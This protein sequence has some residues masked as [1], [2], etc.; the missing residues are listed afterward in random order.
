M[1][2]LV[3]VVTRETEDHGGEGDVL[4]YDN[5]LSYYKEGSAFTPKGMISSKD[6]ISKFN[7]SIDAPD[8]AGY[9]LSKFGDT[10]NSK[11]VVAKKKTLKAGWKYGKQ[12]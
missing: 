11:I 4:C 5:G 12:S 8:F 3:S 1:C 2:I 7:K 6:S 10:L 9:P